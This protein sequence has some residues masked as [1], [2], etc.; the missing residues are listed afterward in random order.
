[1][2]RK[3]IQSMKIIA[4][5]LIA[6]VIVFAA[7]VYAGMAAPNSTTEN[8]ELSYVLAGIVVFSMVTSFFLGWNQVSKIKASESINKRMEI[9]QTALI[10][11]LAPLEG[12]AL[13]GVVVAITN[14]NA[15]YLVATVV[16]V[17]MMLA[18]FPY[19]GRLINDL[20]LSQE[21]I[22]EVFGGQ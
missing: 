11:R 7:I 21:E 16:L 4:L 12:A 14:N 22:Q 20:K 2:Y 5:A 18:Y 8:D 1:M 6:G 13:F 9:Y 15:E 17:V 3:K 19:R 10:L